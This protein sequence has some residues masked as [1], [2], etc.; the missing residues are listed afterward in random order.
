MKLTLEKVLNIQA[1]YSKIQNKKMP[2]KI[3]YKF[4]KFFSALN[5]EAKFYHDQLT[6]IIE[7]YA[8]RD[9]Y[10]KA[11]PAPE[12]I[13]FQIK[14][15]S[16]EECRNALNELFNFQVEIPTTTFTLDELDHLDLSIEEFEMFL[17]FIEE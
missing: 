10:G 16:I 17:P 3:M 11:I 13:G 6:K 8:E 4:S 2:I 9:V 1:L 7:Q 14:K 12:G 5:D 15:D